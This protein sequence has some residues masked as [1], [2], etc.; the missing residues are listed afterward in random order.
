MKSRTLS[1]LITLAFAA[2]SLVPAS[3]AIADSST[4]HYVATTGSDKNPG[5]IDSPFRTIQH[6]GSTAAPGDTCWIRGGTYYEKVTPNVGVSIIGY[7]GEKVTVD[8]RTVIKPTSFKSYGKNRFVA[9]V[10]MALGTANQVFFNDAAGTD[11]KWPNGGDPLHP[12][13]ATLGEGTSDYTL[14]DDFLPEKLR[15][16]GKAKIWSGYDGW[17][18]QTAN[19]KYRTRGQLDIELQSGSNPPFMQPAVNGLYY[20]YDN[21]SLMDRPFEWYFNPNSQ[22]LYV[23]LPAGKKITDYK[24]AYKS[25]NFAFDISNRSQITLRNISIIGATIRSNSNSYENMI[26]GINARYISSFSEADDDPVWHNWPT[27]YDFDHVFETGIMVKGRDNILE[28]S[29]IQFSTCNGV[30]VTGEHNRVINNLISDVGY[31]VNTCSGVFLSGTDQTVKG[32]TIFNTARTAIFPTIVWDHLDNNSGTAPLNADISYNDLFHTS[33]LG[34]DSAAIYFGGGKDTGVKVHHNWIHNSDFPSPKPVSIWPENNIAGVYLD[35][36]TGDV[37]VFQNIFWGLAFRS[38]FINGTLCTTKNTYPNNNSIHNN[39]IPDLWHW[40]EIH[41]G[42]PM[43]DCGTTSVNDNRVWVPV[44]S[45]VQAVCSVSNNS[46]TAVGANE[47]LNVVPGCTLEACKVDP[48][49]PPVMP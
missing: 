49:L 43:Y 46:S 24:V 3:V 9:K 31:L 17:A 10:K 37:E 14:A 18:M 29:V 36:N 21:L 13:W 45:E 6:C 12:S 26:D 35:C 41:V 8:G 28:N 5:T 47:M 44:V 40:S 11:A 38:V 25:R 2:I 20:L 30:L 33:M 27:G 39:T 42:G 34:I 48:Y 23:Q 16:S 1:T 19:F 22:K 7:Q 32:N 4:D 15:G